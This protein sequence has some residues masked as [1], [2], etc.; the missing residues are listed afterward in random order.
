MGLGCALH[1]VPSHTRDSST[2][3][4]S[5]S[6]SGSYLNRCRTLKTSA[7]WTWGGKGSRYALALIFS[8]ISTGPIFRAFNL[9]YWPIGNL[10]LV[11]TAQTESPT[12]K[13]TS[14]R[15]LSAVRLYLMDVPC[16]LSCAFRWMLEISSISST[17]RPW[18]SPCW[19]RGVKDRGPA[20]PHHKQL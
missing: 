2:N 11:R 3:P 6:S 10:S 20:A 15:R 18:N 14:L 16:K 5:K 9:L 13:C 8:M 17:A 7:V 12:W 19:G 1:Q 4:D